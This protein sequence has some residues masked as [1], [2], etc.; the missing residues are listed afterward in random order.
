MRIDAGVENSRILRR[1]RRVRPHR[2]S[3][4]EVVG[5]FKF[6]LFGTCEQ[7]RYRD[8]VRIVYLH[9]PWRLEKLG[10]RG[11]VNLSKDR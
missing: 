2:R 8:C 1:V 10:I 9:E 11:R 7:S 3:A 4:T 5:L 6:G